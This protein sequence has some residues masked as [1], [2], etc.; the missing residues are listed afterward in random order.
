MFRYW[1]TL[2]DKSI[3]PYTLRE[4][5]TSQCAPRG[6]LMPTRSASAAF[7]LFAIIVHRHPSYLV[8]PIVAYGYTASYVLTGIAPIIFRHINVGSN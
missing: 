7:F 2:V 3:A 8:S 1:Y 6:L 4:V 5:V